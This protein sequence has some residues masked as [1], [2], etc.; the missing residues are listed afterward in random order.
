MEQR[1]AIQSLLA[2]RAAS[3]GAERN[4][5]RLQNPTALKPGSLQSVDL[6]QTTTPEIYLGYY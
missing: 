6:A 5:L 4:K 1:K 2:E 3:T